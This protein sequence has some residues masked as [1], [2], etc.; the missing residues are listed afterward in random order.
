MCLFKDKDTKVE[1]VQELICLGEAVV[2]G[3]VRILAWRAGALPM[4]AEPQKAASVF[5]STSGPVLPNPGD[6]TVYSP[7]RREGRET[8]SF[9]VSPTSLVRISLFMGLRYVLKKQSLFSL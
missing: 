6:H 7:Y 8:H 9:G 2:S 4:G 3:G 5:S 1:K